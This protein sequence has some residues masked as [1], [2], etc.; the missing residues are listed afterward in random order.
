MAPSSFI[1]TATPRVM[2]TG[3]QT[4]LESLMPYAC[5][6]TLETFWWSAGPPYPH[7]VAGEGVAS[8]LGVG[9]DRTLPVF[10]PL[11]SDRV[12]RSTTASVLE[13]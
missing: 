3:A 5:Q 10:L 11:G 4:R 7:G 8:G 2:R 6:N 13:L 1:R 12:G 9:L